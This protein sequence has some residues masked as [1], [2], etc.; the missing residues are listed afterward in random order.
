VRQKTP[1]PLLLTLGIYTAPAFGAFTLLLLVLAPF[2][3]G[4]YTIN[5]E[6]VTGAEFLRSA[7]PL[8]AVLGIAALAIAYAIW[9]ERAWSRW[10]IV[11]FWVAQLAGAVGL[12]WAD[13]GIG[14]AAGAVASL[15]LVVTLVAWYLFG[16]ENVVAYYQ[17]LGKEDSAREARRSAHRS[18]DA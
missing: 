6:E 16:K 8:F 17:S 11:A 14:G 9:Q 3:A 13:G 1:R 10:A 5:G 15:L 7:G 18:D 12:G 4:T 2:N